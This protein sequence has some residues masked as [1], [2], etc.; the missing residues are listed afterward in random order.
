VRHA[1]A[2]VT[3]RDP[4][5]IQGTLSEQVTALIA[6][7]DAER[8]LLVLD[9]LE[10]LL[11]AYHRW[12]AAQMQDDSVPEE[13]EHRACT[14]PDDADALA[15]LATVTRSRILITSRLFPDALT[16]A[17]APMRGVVAFTLHGQEGLRGLNP[18]DARTLWRAL[19]IRWSSGDEGALDSFFNGIGRHGLLLKLAAGAIK[20][21]RRANGSFTAWFAITEGEIDFQ[22]ADVR[23]KRHHILAAAFADLSAEARALLEQIAVFGTA[24]GFETLNT[25]NPFLPPAPEEV[26]QPNDEPYSLW[27]ARWKLTDADTDDERAHGQAEPERETRAL[28]DAQAAYA[29]YLTAHAAYPKSSA[30]KRGVMRFEA[31]LHDL[32]MRGLIWFDS[33]ADLYDLHPV[34]RGYVY[35]ALSP[36]ERRARHARTLDLFAAQE[37]ALSSDAATTLADLQV[38]IAM[39]QALIGA[40]RLDDAAALYGRRLRTP[41]QQT[42]AAYPTAYALLL[43]LFPDGLDRPPALAD[44]D[45]QGARLTNMANV[46]F[47]LGRSDAARTLE[48]IRIELALDRRKDASLAV[49]LGNYGA[50]LHE[51]SRL[52]AALDVFSALRD[53]A[54]AAV[55]DRVWN[56]QRRLLAIDATLGRWVEA[57]A[58]YRAF[59]TAPPPDRT[60][61]WQASVERT[62]AKSLLQR[63]APLEAVEASLAAAEGYAVKGGNALES[64]ILAYLRGEVA[65][66]RG[67]PAAAAAHYNRAIALGNQSGVRYDAAFGGLA[68]ASWLLAQPR[69]AEAA[70]L[71]QRALRIVDEGCDDYSA[72]VVLRDDGQAD[73]ARDRAIAYYTWAWADGEP[74]VWRYE[75]DRAAALL[76]GMGVPLPVLP[77]YD[78]SKAR[79]DHDEAVKAYIAALQAKKQDE[80]DS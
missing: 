5:S 67:D 22:G 80:L 56:A 69:P 76:T 45:Q 54:Q 20:Q 28:A 70:R 39:V 16:E 44:P 34:V 3:R 32:E 46:L 41:L 72:A 26:E 12:D 40:G 78:E 33:S 75:L 51:A 38:P 50:S 77:A 47:Y 15:R 43:P 14:V 52:A 23:A 62:Y 11:V 10:R 7:L 66:R 1:L 8:H 42:F 68:R 71:R 73:A 35:G 6:A 4:E 36:D 61:L 25:F 49:A 60:A 2:Y 24:V 74:Y 58:A 79:W 55:L 48:A 31:L 63:G 64:R 30:Y 19:G 27:N 29:A 65:L 9:G 13:R 57:D 18:T 59:M 21:S 17:G 53:L 37:R